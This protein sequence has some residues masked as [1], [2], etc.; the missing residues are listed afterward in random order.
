MSRS[1]GNR[2]LSW[3]SPTIR[4]RMSRR[5]WWRR[6]VAGRSRVEFVGGR[7]VA[8]RLRVEFV[9]GRVVAGRSRVQSGA[10]LRLSHCS[11]DSWLCS[12]CCFAFF[13]E[14]FF[15]RTFMCLLW[16]SFTIFWKVVRSGFT[17]HSSSFFIVL[18]V[19]LFMGFYRLRCA[20][21]LRTPRWFW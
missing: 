13:N 8:G 18:P 19:L 10:R 4:E 3:F 20:R 9:G 16:A 7:V 21:L 11:A 5:V 6:V 1:L 2:C 14:V 17:D 15:F 12:T